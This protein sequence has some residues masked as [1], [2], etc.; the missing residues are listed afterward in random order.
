MQNTL[1]TRQELPDD[2]RFLID[3]YPRDGWTTHPNFARSIQNWLGAHQ[4]FRQLSEIL[5]SKTQ[6]AIDNDIDQSRYVADLGYY[7]DALVRNLHGHHT[8]E[9]RT[10]FPEL[11]RADKRFQTGQD[12]LE[13]YHL[14]LDA[15]LDDITKRSNRVIK[16]FDLDQSQISEELGPLE[17]ALSKLSLFLNRHLT[18]EE[19]LIVP[20]L[21]HHK[22]RG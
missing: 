14:E 1:I 21:L 7:G 17:H 10:Y 4:M 11:A 5:V 9:D 16:L 3:G 8:W 22:M 15:V 18:D 12:L 19:D 13:S 20:I 2:I 6:R